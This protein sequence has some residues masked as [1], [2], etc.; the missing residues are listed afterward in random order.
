MNNARYKNFRKLLL[1]AF[2]IVVGVG[3]LVFTASLVD[4]LKYEERKK[5]EL[6]AEAMQLISLSD[7][8]QDVDFLFSIID[9]NNTIP[10]ILADES[11]EIISS[12]N[13]SP[14][15]MED[16]EY[17]DRTLMKIKEYRDPIVIALDNRH[18]NLVYYKDSAI[19][20]MLM[21]YP[22]VQFGIIALFIAVSYLAFSASMVADHNMVWAAMSRET[23]H[24]LGT[25]ASSLAGWVEVLRQKHPEVV[26]TEEIS[27]DVERL[28]KITERFSRI[29]TKAALLST[30]IVQLILRTAGYLKMRTSSKIAFKTDFS[31]CSTALTV[32]INTA[33]FEWVI[34]NV[35]KNAIDAMEGNGTI[36]FQ[37][38]EAEKNVIIDI[39]DTGKGIPKSAFNKIFIAGFSTKQRGWGVGLSLSK[40]IVE[41]YHN[42]RIFVKHSEA[43]RGSCIRIVLLKVQTEKI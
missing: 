28:E 39:S 30:D 22:Y 36:T 14:K 23:A 41:D 1:L 9:N 33:L 43:G 18:F 13:F 17:L 7:T 16:P 3:S 5:A 10:V 19:L 27:R 42:G 32:P 35:S 29:G 15:K 4:R 20:T 34:E 31:H 21:Y 6:W 40:R 25:P 24:Q 11:N 38:R 12:R 2:A 8:T 26:I 37:V